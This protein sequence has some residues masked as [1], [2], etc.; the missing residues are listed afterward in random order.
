MKEMSICEAKFKAYKDRQKAKLGPESKLRCIQTLLNT[1][2]RSDCYKHST[3][4]HAVVRDIE[5]IL[6]D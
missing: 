4:A 2:K 5:R 1:I 3:T 6:N